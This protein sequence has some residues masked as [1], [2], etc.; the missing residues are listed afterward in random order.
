MFG[1]WRKFEMEKKKRHPIRILFI[2]LGVF[3][4]VTAISVLITLNSGRYPAPSSSPTK[5]ASEIP[6]ASSKVDDLELLDWKWERGDYDIR[7]LVGRV[8]NN[9]SRDYSYVQI[10]INLYDKGKALVGSTMTNVNDLGSGEIWKFKAMV[11]EDSA[12]TAKLKS[13]TGF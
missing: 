6:G 2:V 1:A 11:S 9:S 8:K 13:L 7:Y 5:S 10:S 4:A 12:Y 3:A